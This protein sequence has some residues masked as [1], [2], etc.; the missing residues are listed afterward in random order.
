MATHC[1]I[2][3]FF[4]TSVYPMKNTKFSTKKTV[5]TAVFAALILLATFL[6]RIPTPAFGYIHVG[7]GFVLLA[8]VFL[9]PGLGGLAAGIGSGLSDLIGGYPV[10]APGSFVIKFLTALT[11]ALLYRFLT[12]K[13]R[14][15]TAGISVPSVIIAGI[16]GEAVM[17]IGYFLYNILI[18]SLASGSV[19][20]TGLAAAVTVSLTEIPFNIAQGCIGIVLSSLLAPLFSGLLKQERF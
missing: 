2:Y 16:A 4:L 7:D 14:R 11:A 15:M 12:K 1:F 19:S 8:A 6:F 13:L 17:I 10:W 18:I 9:G 5:Y 3:M 20:G